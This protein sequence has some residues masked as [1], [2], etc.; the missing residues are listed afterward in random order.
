M[1]LKH[2]DL[3]RNAEKGRLL[4]F[5][6]CCKPVMSLVEVLLPVFR[7]P[8]VGG[9]GISRRIEGDRERKRKT[10]ICPASR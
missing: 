2:R 6:G 1:K 10:P 8:I 4:T 9:I 3:L 7:I 5:T